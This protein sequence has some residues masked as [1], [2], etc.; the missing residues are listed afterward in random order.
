MNS[1]KVSLDVHHYDGKLGDSYS[2]LVKWDDDYL[3]PPPSFDDSINEFSDYLNLI[4]TNPEKKVGNTLIKLVTNHHGNYDPTNKINFEDI[5]SRVWRFY[6][7][8]EDKADKAVFLQQFLDINKGTCP[9]G[10]S[11]ARLYQLYYMWIDHGRNYMDGTSGS[12]GD[13]T[14]DTI[15][16]VMKK[17]WKHVDDL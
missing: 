15:V 5:M 2:E 4:G 8:V 1:D 17:L 3:L 12:G 10:R 13:D 14:N 6:R 11:G 9:Q 7:L 16:K